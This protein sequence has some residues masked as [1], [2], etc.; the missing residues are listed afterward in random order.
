MALSQDLFIKPALSDQAKVWPS[1]E[2]PEAQ[3]E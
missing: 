2:P 3:A 1:A